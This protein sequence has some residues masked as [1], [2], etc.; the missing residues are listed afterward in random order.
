[1]ISTIAV[2]TALLVAA[3]LLLARHLTVWRRA[4]HGG[5]TD[6]DYEFHHRQYRRRMQTTG[7]LGI[8]GLLMLGS[9]WIADPLVGAVYWSGIAAL[10]VWVALLALSDWLASRLYYGRLAAAH[11][12]EHA[13]IKAEIAKFHR[14]QTDDGENPPATSD[15]SPE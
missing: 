2:G 4:D 3:G 6:G 14:E 11:A 1:M 12:V 13:A 7:L 10:V 5:L 8:V 15:S 9:L